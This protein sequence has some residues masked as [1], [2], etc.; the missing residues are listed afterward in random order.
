M[1]SL[2]PIPDLSAAFG[3]APA[4]AAASP[5]IYSS[6]K[7]PKA[8]KS[9]SSPIRPKRYSVIPGTPLTKK[10]RVG[11]KLQSPQKI[12]FKG[13][14]RTVTICEFD[15]HLT[16]HSIPDSTAYKLTGKKLTIIKQTGKKTCGATCAMMLAI[17]QLAKK[18]KAAAAPVSEKADTPPAAN[19]AS[20]EKE[21]FSESFFTWFH[22]SSLTYGPDLITHLQREGFDPV[23]I[24]FSKTDPSSKTAKDRETIHFENGHDIIKALSQKILENGNS[25]IIAIFHPVISAHWIIVDNI[26]LDQDGEP[27][28]CNIRDPFTGKAYEMPIEDLS[29]LIND[30]CNNI[31]A[32]YLQN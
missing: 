18:T 15:R 17:D 30:G 14:I 12:L 22:S 27:K 2:L 24:T 28:F 32:V 20:E 9:E 25:I 11:H 21:L 13:E 31:E 26:S 8:H 5:T 7:H 29:R 19:S 16:F 1:S 23:L 10:S 4:A 3:N 6:P